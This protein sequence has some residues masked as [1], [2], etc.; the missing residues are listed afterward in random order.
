MVEKGREWLTKVVRERHRY[1]RS[2]K[3]EEKENML[4][5]NKEQVRET[6]TRKSTWHNVARRSER[7]PREGTRD[8]DNETDVIGGRGIIKDRIIKDRRYKQQVQEVEL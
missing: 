1:R 8:F 3:E 4:Y 7:K 2:R 5:L 6:R